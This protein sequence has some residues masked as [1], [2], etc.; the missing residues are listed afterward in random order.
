M[1]LLPALLLLLLLQQ[2]VVLL[3]LL[4]WPSGSLESLH[5]AAKL[6]PDSDLQGGVR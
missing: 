5:A 3:L 4:S 6:G 2:V 1:V